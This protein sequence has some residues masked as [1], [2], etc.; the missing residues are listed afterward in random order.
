MRKRQSKAKKETDIETEL[1]TDDKEETRLIQSFI[2]VIIASRQ[3]KK[4]LQ[5]DCR[6]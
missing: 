3:W 1:L 4:F 2:G 5:H 6:I